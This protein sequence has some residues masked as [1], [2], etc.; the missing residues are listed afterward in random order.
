MLV[1]RCGRC[2][3]SDQPDLAIRRTSAFPRGL[4]IR[5]SSARTAGG[6]GWL[7]RSALG[8][9]P[10]SP[11]QVDYERVI[12]WKTALLESAARGFFCTTLR[13]PP[14]DFKR[15]AKRIATGWMISRCSWRSSANSGAVWSRW[16][17][18]IRWRDPRR[19]NGR[20]RL[21]GPIQIQ[22]FLQFAFFTQWRELRDYART[23]GVRLMGDLP[24]YVAHDSADVWANPQYFELDAEGNPTV[25]AGVPPDYFSATGQLWGNPIY[26]G[27]RW[28]RT[29][30]LVAGSVSRGVGDGGYDPAGPFPRLR[31]VLGGS[32]GGDNRR[33]GPLGER[34]GQ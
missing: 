23:R 20:E 27:M 29:G 3:R 15:S 30:S 12:P 5:C 2:C 9:A 17:P 32:G 16:E 25:V 7:E 18:A 11:A 31:S 21:A 1:R 8:G 28:R 26:R 24:I 6:A 33:Q 10:A 13:P 14:S 34:A 4:A 22:K 19:L